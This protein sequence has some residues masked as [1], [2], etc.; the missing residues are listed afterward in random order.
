MQSKVCIL[1]TKKLRPGQRQYLL[2]AGLSVIDADFINVVPREFNANEINNCLIFTSQNAL[3]SFME[4]KKWP[5]Y[6]DKKTF[7]VGSNTKLAL[8][9][10]GF[11]VTA[12]ADYAADLAKIIVYEYRNETYTFFSGSIRRDILP[13]ALTDFGVKFNEIEVYQTMLTPHSIKPG[14]DGILFFS[15]SAV[16][17]Y[18]KENKTEKRMC[19]CIGTTTAEALNGITENIAIATRPT[20]DNVIIKCIKYYK[21]K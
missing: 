7:C 15:P 6:L 9:N 16:A 3:K 20:I 8:E 13:H 1:S 14:V 2:N 21:S 5:E 4:N 11:V 10:A 12:Y 18:L 17:S 19:F